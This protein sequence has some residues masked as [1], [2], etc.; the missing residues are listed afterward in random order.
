M[1]GNLIVQKYGGT[2]VGTLDKIRKVARRIK[3]SRDAGK[4]VLVVVSAMAGETDKLLA[5]AH[6]LSDH[7]NRR[8]TDLLLSSGERI[9]SAL[10]SIALHSM[11]CPAMALTGRRSVGRVGFRSG[12]VL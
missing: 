9:S 10:L 5:M 2:S 12:R 4:D 6:E 11:G 8:E 3:K 1:S 7:P